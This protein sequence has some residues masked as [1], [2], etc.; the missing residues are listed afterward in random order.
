[1][2]LESA[3][4][5]CNGFII[6][7]TILPKSIFEGS[8]GTCESELEGIIGTRNLLERDWVRRLADEIIKRAP[9]RTFAGSSVQPVQCTYFAKTIDRNWLVPLHRDLKIPVRERINANG[10]KRWSVK[11]G[12]L[13]VQPP[14]VVLKQMIA[15]RIHLEDNTAENGALRVMPGSHNRSNKNR[16][17][18]ICEVARGGALVMR[19]LILHASSRIMKGQR[20]VLHFLF[21]PTVLPDGARWPLLY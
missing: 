12:Y 1:M 20:R 15:V 3:Q 17:R 10:W 2:S 16:E 6:L 8:I 19:P 13:Y 4:F 9:V 7:D 5:E 14:A 21:G 18:T 11:E